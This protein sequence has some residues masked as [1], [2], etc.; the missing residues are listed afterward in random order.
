MFGYTYEKLEL[1]QSIMDYVRDKEVVDAEEIIKMIGD[2]TL[3]VDDKREIANFL[4][5][6][7]ETFEAHEYLDSLT[8]YCDLLFE[9]AD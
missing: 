5:D 1:A 2:S 9:S 4:I 3:D 8:L 6:A 7:F